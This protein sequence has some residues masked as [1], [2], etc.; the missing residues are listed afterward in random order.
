MKVLKKIRNLKVYEKLVR[1]GD[2]RFRSKEKTI[3]AIVM[4]GEWLRELGFGIGDQ[5]QV[6]CSDGKLTITKAEAVAVAP[7]IETA[8]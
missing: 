4:Q 2:P 5:I 6:E 7:G 1:F 3:P 8:A